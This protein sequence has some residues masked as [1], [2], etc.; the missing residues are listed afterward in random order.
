MLWCTPTLRQVGVM[1]VPTHGY[2]TAVRSHEGPVRAL[3]VDPHNR[4][5]P[6]QT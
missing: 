5:P 1:D 6:R 2:R 4:R 3:A